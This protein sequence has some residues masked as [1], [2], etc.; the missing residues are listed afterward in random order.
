MFDSK[1]LQFNL[2]PKIFAC[3][4]FSQKNAEE[5]IARRRLYIKEKFKPPIL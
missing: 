2:K 4:I 3:S 1:V 5:I